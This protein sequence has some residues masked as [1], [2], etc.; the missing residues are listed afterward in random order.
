MKFIFSR[1][2]L[3]EGAWVVSSNILGLLV[4]LYTINLI[5]SKLNI[6][7]YGSLGLILT[8]QGFFSLVFFG[9]INNGIFRFSSI[10]IQVQRAKNYFTATLKMGILLGVFTIIIGFFSSIVFF[11]GYK[12]LIHPFN[13]VL[14]TSILLG[15]SDFILS[16]LLSL[17]KRKIIFFIKLIESFFKISLLYLIPINDYFDVLIIYF[18][19]SLINYLLLLYFFKDKL[20]GLSFFFTKFEYY[21]L[22]K[23]LIYSYPFLIWGIFGWAQQSSVKWALEIYTSRNDIG[24]FN[25]LMQIGYS[26]VIILFGVLMNFITP[27]IFQKINPSSITLNSK[28]FLRKIL[29][30]SLICILLLFFGTLILVPISPFIVDILFPIEYISISKYVPVV[31][32][33]SG[34]YSTTNFLANIPFSLNKPKSLLKSSVYSS[35]VGF[36]S[37]FLFIYLFGFIGG[38]YAVLFHSIFY[39]LITTFK[40]KESYANIL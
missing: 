20:K 27:I 10:S 24:L 37:A 39:L 4:T 1:K 17:R 2:V 3:S 7:Q 34:L 30:V 36:I 31:F 35:V 14:G 29:N 19:V 9:S 28:V 5:T 33:A 13:I 6:S 25:A 26:P 22:K 21:W 11:F 16:I 8:I 12:N 18:L 38:I 15:L 40:V 23:I 32:L